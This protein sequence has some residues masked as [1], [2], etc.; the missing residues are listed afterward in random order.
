MAIY[1]FSV[2]CYGA[3]YAR[4]VENHNKIAICFMA[5]EMFRSKSYMP[6]PKKYTKISD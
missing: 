3:I 5:S 4:L 1:L 6:K 2:K